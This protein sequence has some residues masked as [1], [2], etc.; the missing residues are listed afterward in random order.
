KPMRYAMTT[1]LPKQTGNHVPKPGELIRA[2]FSRSCTLVVH[3]IGPPR[4]GKTQLIEATLKQLP[5]PGRVVVITVNPASSRDAQRLQGV[6]GRV[7]HLDAAVPDARDVWRALSQL[8]PQQSD[9]VL[10]ESAGGLAPLPDLGQ[11]ETAAVLA[12]SG[13]DDKA[14]EYSSMLKKA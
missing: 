1:S 3:L 2:H 6:C 12:V 9:F 5:S 11:D 4:S 8:D 10:I 7:V 14:A 13:G